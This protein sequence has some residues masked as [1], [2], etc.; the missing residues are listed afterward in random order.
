VQ[1]KFFTEG[2]AICCLGQIVN[3]THYLHSKSICHRD[4]KPQN[5]LVSADGV[6]KLSDFGLSLKMD[7]YGR[8]HGKAGTDGYTPPE[9]DLGEYKGIPGDIFAIGIVFYLM[10]K[11][12]M[13]FRVSSDQNIS[14]SLKKIRYPVDNISHS[15]SL[16]IAKLMSEDPGMRPS[17][18][19]LMNFCTNSNIQ[20]DS[21]C[22]K[23]LKLWLKLETKKQPEKL[24]AFSL[25]N[26]LGSLAF[27]LHLSAGEPEQS[28]LLRL[29]D[30]SNTLRDLSSILC[31][32]KNVYFR[33]YDHIVVVQMCVNLIQAA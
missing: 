32:L 30:F 23:S 8:V 29:T 16:M 17:T 4:I 18:I 9:A 24:D 28:V 20:C 26:I 7:N 15:S 1:H 6:C 27:N 13:P 11:G 10:L 21:L 5:I 14:A 3:G 2:L 33:I 19:D 12:E 31:S 25:L 22:E